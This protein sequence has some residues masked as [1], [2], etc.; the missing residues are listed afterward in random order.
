MRQIANRCG[1]SGLSAGPSTAQI[2]TGASTIAA[3]AG[4]STAVAVG[5]LPALAI[6]IAGPVI[7]GL[8]LLAN[9]LFQPDVNKLQTTSI[10]DQMEPGLKALVAQWKQLP[11]SARTPQAQQQYL[12]VFLQAWAQVVNSC[13]GQCAAMPANGE[14]VSQA[15]CAHSQYGS[16]GRNCVGDRQRGGK[17][18]WWSYYYDPIATDP[19][20]MSNVQ[21][22]PLTEGQVNIA[23]MEVSPMVLI[24]GA[25]IL[26]V[27]LI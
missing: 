22:N 12:N 4:V 19:A 16:A 25:A 8:A 6:P 18:D 24:A 11:V 9:L 21:S 5:V 15:C 14:G 2:A 26:G 23:G 10:V 13:C 1:V 20:V 27:M 17:W 3:T 7:A